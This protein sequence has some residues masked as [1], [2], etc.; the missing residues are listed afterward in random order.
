MGVACVVGDLTDEHQG[1]YIRVDDPERPSRFDHFTLG[2]GFGSGVRRFTYNG[3]KWVGL[4]DDKR[5]PGVVGTERIF[6]ADTPC[7][8]LRQIKRP[9]KKVSR[10]R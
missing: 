6:R 9:R 3:V 5:S 1:W 8:L 10:V 2:K 7:V 4:T